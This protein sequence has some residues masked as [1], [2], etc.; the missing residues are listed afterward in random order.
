M[1]VRAIEYQPREGH[2]WSTVAAEQMATDHL[3]A[4]ERVA[5]SI[6]SPVEM[7][8]ALPVGCTFA[9]DMPDSLR[10][11]FGDVS[12]TDEGELA[13]W[14]EAIFPELEDS[15]E[16]AAELCGRGRVRRLRASFPARTWNLFRLHIEAPDFSDVNAELK[17]IPGTIVVLENALI[18][19][20]H[21]TD[22]TEIG[23]SAGIDALVRGGH[24]TGSRSVSVT[25]V[26]SQ[27]AVEAVNAAAET[28]VDAASSVDV[29]ESRLFESVGQRIAMP[30]LVW[31]GRLRS[32]ATVLRAKVDQ[33]NA[34]V[35][36][37][38]RRFI[39]S[40]NDGER[41]GSVVDG[42]IED[43]HL[44]IAQLRADVS[45]A[46]IAA[47]TV[48]IAEQL[49]LGQR[50][51]DQVNRLQVGVTRLT[52]FLLVPGLVA[53]VFGAN[54]ALP[55]STGST[56]LW[57]MLGTMVVGAVLTYVVLRRGSSDT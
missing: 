55:G 12:S 22:N 25:K 45:D 20:W 27:Y 51:Q 39:W 41:I 47:N 3:V 37:G 6:A 5:D 23:V 7:R 33:L 32:C 14:L 29:W 11:V 9:G 46:F 56:R 10:I 13:G 28:A 35:Q 50:Q 24:Y 53:A 30:D 54:V 19:L 21:D 38:Q 43:A 16:I 49:S 42:E 52:A 2:G 26:A 8:Q 1:Y 31:L 18:V 44:R 17:W 40:G 36:S 4:A 48:A 57:L 15:K 34:Q